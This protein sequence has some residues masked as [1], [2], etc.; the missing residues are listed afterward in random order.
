MTIASSHAAIEKCNLRLNALREAERPIAPRC[1]GELR[2]LALSVKDVI[3]VKGWAITCS[4]RPFAGRR[5]TRDAVVVA[6]SFD[7]EAG[8][9]PEVMDA[10]EAALS[11]FERMGAAV[12]EAAPASSLRLYHAAC[13]IVLL[14]EAWRAHRKR[15][16]SVRSGYDPRTWARLALGAFISQSSYRKALALRVALR[17]EIDELFAGFDVLVTAGA[18]APAGNPSAAAPFGMLSTVFLTTPFSL[19]GHPALAMPIGFD[20]GGLPLSMQLVAP[21]RRESVLLAAAAAHRTLR[22]WQLMMPSL[23]EESA[24]VL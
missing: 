14:Y 3:Y 8:T 21:F 18:L 22:P 15:L 6:R 11:D 12:C 23:E 1:D 19:T 16:R 4:H 24:R 9:E 17:A 10:V 2:D 13:I 20:R 7:T 5:P